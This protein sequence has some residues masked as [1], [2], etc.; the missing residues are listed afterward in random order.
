MKQQFVIQKDSESDR[1]VI[2]EYAELDKDI[3][4]FL[5]EQTY[6]AKEIQAA[7]SAGK[8]VLITA[9]RTDN[10]YPPVLYAKEIADS[11]MAVFDTDE[12]PTRELLFEDVEE[13]SEDI[14]ELLDEDIDEEYDAEKLSNGF[15]SSIKVAEDET[16]DVEEDT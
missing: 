13:D 1:L 7:I 3:L 11:V 5:C 12:S 4:S 9:L 14:D 16:L 2:K 10:M 15:N 8:E 6:D